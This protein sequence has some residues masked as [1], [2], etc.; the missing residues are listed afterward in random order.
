MKDS[1][2]NLYTLIHK[3]LRASLCQ[4]LVDLGKPNATISMLKP[5]LVSKGWIKPNQNLHLE[6]HANT[7]A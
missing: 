7:T 6:Q 2:Y 1:H 3:A 5:L 4:N